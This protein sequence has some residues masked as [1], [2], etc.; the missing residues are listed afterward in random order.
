MLF[1]PLYIDPG[2]G[3][4][5]F[6]IL[7]AGAATV[8]F[9][10]RALSIKLKLLFS[11]GR[12][13]VKTAQAV[14][15]YSEGVQYWNVFKPVLEEF[16]R[17]GEALHY[18]S[19]AEDDPVFERAWRFVTAEYIGKGNKAFSRLN[20]L[21][22]DVAL[23]TTPGLDV[24]QLKRSKTVR[25]YAHVLHA[26][27]DAT[28]YR[29]FGLDYFDSVLL[30]G[31]YQAKDIRELERLRGLPA[32]ELV[33]VGCTYLDVFA[34]KIADIP[35]EAEKPVTVLISPSWGPS[36]LLSRY[37]EKL[38]TPLVKTGWRII[39]RPHPQSRTSERSM[40]DALSARYAESANLVWDYEREN[41][42][43]LGKADIMISDFSGIIFD[44]V[45][46][47]DKPVMYVSSDMDLRPYDAGDLGED[48]QAKLWQFRAV[49]AFGI[50][51]KE[52]LFEEIEKHIQ[53]ALKSDALREARKEAKAAAWQHEGEA[54]ARIADFL[55][56]KTVAKTA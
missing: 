46:L 28:L 44:Y 24:Y 23:F 55:L 18:L 30:T 14:V 27:S 45:F 17:R 41:I 48:A 51:L 50:E 3:S 15:V 47:F 2:T 33:T 38:L 5:L 11:G 4:A 42:Y 49:A 34:Q 54:G 25:H 10:A 8:Y 20:F 36:A 7:I 22:A 1:F 29:L 53:A 39:V 31:D 37:G 35:V 32:K 56:S 16:E 52:E 12:A 13:V 9:L 21:S 6:S 40:L 26:A 43:A 19:S